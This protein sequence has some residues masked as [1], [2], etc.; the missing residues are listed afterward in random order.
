MKNYLSFGGGVNSVAMYLYLMDQG[1]TPGDSD[2]GFEA[3]FVDHG[4]DWPETYIYADMFIGK[5]YPITIIKPQVGTV[6]GKIF[7]NLYDYY[8]FKRVFPFRQNGA[9]TGRFKVETLQRYQESPAFVFIGYALD[10]SHRA[11][12]SSEKGFEYRYPLIENEINREM[13]KQIIR[14]HG[15]RVPRKSGCFVCP[16]QSVREYKELRRVHP[17]LFCKAE[18]LENGYIQRRKSEGKP[19]LYMLKN[20][21][22]RT[23]IDENQLSLFTED[24]YP[25]CECM[26]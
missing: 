22:I 23:L 18:Q 19:P 25:P 2:N 6:E 5:G 15:L 14:D 4:T 24:E 7:D 11:K 20:N 13:C 8:R 26:L 12:L 17:D 3:V 1:M 16:Y 10:E 9:C 21:T